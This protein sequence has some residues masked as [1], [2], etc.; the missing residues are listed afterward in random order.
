[1]IAKLAVASVRRRVGAF[2]GTFLTA[3]LAVA[4]ISGSGLLL[5]S[6]LTA[7]PGGDRFAA[8]DVVVAAGRSVELTTRHDKGDE[9]KVKTKTERLTGAR[10]LP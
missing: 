10:P 3:F 9:V 7:G 8:A 1:M 2:A 4:L 5:H 6:V